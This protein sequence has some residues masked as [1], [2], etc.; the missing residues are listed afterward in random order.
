MHYLNIDKIINFAIVYEFTITWK[1]DIQYKAIN[2]T[3]LIYKPLKT[4]FTILLHQW[5]EF[6]FDTY[7]S[8]LL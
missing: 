6:L 8:K 4:W 7:E 2:V 3:I 5:Y 1:I